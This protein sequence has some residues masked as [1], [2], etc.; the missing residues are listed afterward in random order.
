MTSSYSH[1]DTDLP[2]LEDDEIPTVMTFDGV[3]VVVYVDPDGTEHDVFYISMNG[4]L[5]FSYCDCED[6]DS[7]DEAPE[8]LIALLGF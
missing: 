2:Y 6:E 5:H 8:D 4:E 3:P 7:F 1:L